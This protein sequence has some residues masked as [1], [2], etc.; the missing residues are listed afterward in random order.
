MGP[1]PRLR[2]RRWRRLWVGCRDR[3][4]TNGVEIRIV[5]GRGG[6]WEF[7]D[8]G[9][10]GLDEDDEF[11][12]SLCIAILETINLA[13]ASSFILDDDPDD[14]DPFFFKHF[15]L[16]LP[17]GHGSSYTSSSSSSPT[18][19]FTLILASPDSVL[20][21]LDPDVL[22]ELVALWQ[23]LE[24]QYRKTSIQNP[25]ASSFR[26]V[27][28][29]HPLVGF[30]F[31]FGGGAATSTGESSRALRLS[32]ENTFGCE[33]NWLNAFGCEYWLNAY[34]FWYGSGAG[35]GFR[36]DWFGE[37][38]VLVSGKT[39]RDP[40]IG[41]CKIKCEQIRGAEQDQKLRCK[42]QCEQQYQEK[43]GQRQGGGGGGNG[44]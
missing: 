34:G 5:V 11:S 19:T 35:V 1:R 27:L 7:L 9:V 28:F 12:R 33:E 31:D 42:Q 16:S 21:E 10:V 26:A 41:D 37:A 23:N 25:S 4:G 29:W 8:V 6:K 18:S 43:Q 30:G 39:G 38:V 13:N 17:I 15:T 3:V 44:Q 14:L 22:C 20:N 40:V 32:N 24:L 2:R 36:Y